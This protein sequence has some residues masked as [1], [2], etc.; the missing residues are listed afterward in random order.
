MNGH[1][2]ALIIATVVYAVFM[3]GIAYMARKRA[4]KTTSDYY[5]ANRTFGA[6]VIFW[7]LF[8]T[9]FSAWTFLG[10]AGGSYTNGMAWWILA[11]ADMTLGLSGYYF[12]SRLW[13]LGNKFHYV[14][15]SQWMDHRY[16]S[17][18]LR[19]LVAAFALIAV[20]PHVS[21]QITGIGTL[22]N[23]ISNGAIS[24]NT[25][26]VI[27]LLL[28]TFVTIVGVRAVAWSDVLQ[29]IMLFAALWVA[30]IAIFA[31]NDVGGLVGLFTKVKT[32]APELIGFP[33]SWSNKTW[34]AWFFILAPAIIV[35]PQV[36][37]KFIGSKDLNVIRTS[38]GL[39]PY[40]IPLTAFPVIM[41][42]LLGVVLMPDLANADYVIPELLYNFTSPVLAA[43]LG[44]GG[45]AAALST[46]SAIMLC[47]SAIIVKDIISLVNPDMPE[48]KQLRLGKF[49]VVIWIIVCLILGIWNPMLIAYMGAFALRCTGLCFFIPYFGALYWPRSTK[50]GAAAGMVTG[51]VVGVLTTWVIP[52][53]LGLD[54]VIWGFIAEA[55]VYFAVCNATTPPP[56]D[57]LKI[58]FEDVDEVLEEERQK[59]AAAYGSK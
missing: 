26:L 55:I 8:A 10:M 32:V 4:Q 3:L 6:V 31:A 1:T 51:F 20:I 24:F 35:Y 22:Y 58:F 12:G 7:T 33:G 45:I 21:I 2:L 50:Q 39:M 53:P 19:I 17:K 49:F 15:P 29:G 38:Q 59:R 56:A 25:G 30:M 18:P 27:F 41:C 43:I 52:S 28:L 48:D 40:A 42:G 34:I 57:H 46:V 37:T 11:I 13:V 47:A 44:M 5:V 14:T 16:Q 9:L 36:I 54:P 23:G